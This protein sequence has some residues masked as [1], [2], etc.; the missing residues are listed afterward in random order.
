MALHSGL[1][2]QDNHSLNAAS[3]PDIATRNADLVFNDNVDNVNKLVRVNSPI[4]YFILSSINPPVW[5]EI[6]GVEAADTLAEILAIGNVT[7]GS[8]IVVDT[9]DVITLTD[10]PVAGTDGANKDYVDTQVSTSDEL[11][12]VLAIGNTTG[13]NDIIVDAGQVVTLNDG[14][15][16]GTDA[17]NKDYVDAQVG[18]NN[19]LS[20]ILV[21]GNT[22]G[23]T[24][25]L[26]SSGDELQVADTVTIGSLVSAPTDVS[27]FLSDSTNALLINQ[28]TTAQRDAIT[29]TEG[30]QYYNLDVNDLE[31]YNGVFWQSMGG[32]DV[33]GPAS[34]I[35]NQVVIFNGITGKNIQ[36]GVGVIIPAANKMTIGTPGVETPTL[37][38][39]STDPGTGGTQQLILAA[40]TANADAGLAFKTDSITSNLWQFYLSDADNALILGRVGGFEFFKVLSNGNV[41]I[42]TILPVS[43]LH[44]ETD[45]TAFGGSTGITMDNVAITGDAG[46]AFS[47]EDF[48]LNL[49]TIFLSQADG[50]LKFGR[51]D[52]PNKLVILDNGNIGIN[53]VLPIAVLDIVHP[54]APLSST[55]M[56]RVANDANWN[57]RILQDLDAGANI[58]YHIKQVAAS[59]EHDV[60]AFKSGDVGIGTVTPVSK[61]EVET[62]TA[63]L[64]GTKQLTLTNINAAGDAGIAFQTLNRT[65]SLWQAFLSDS[66]NRFTIG[67]DGIGNFLNILD[68]GNV[69]IG[70][71]APSNLLDVVSGV[72]GSAITIDG[73]FASKV[74]SEAT[75]IFTMADFPAPIGGLITLPSGMYII[76]E[77]LVTSD[78][79]FFDSG[80][81][82]TIRGDDLRNIIFTYTG[83]STMFIGTDFAAFCIENSTIVSVGDG[84]QFFDF[85]G[86]GNVNITSTSMAMFG[87]DGSLGN[88]DGSAQLIVR[89]VNGIGFTGGFVMNDI[90]IGQFQ[91]VGMQADNAID[92][93]L[94][95]ITGNGGPGFTFSFMFA[96]LPATGEIFDIEPSY[97]G[98]VNILAVVP[99]G[100]G[101]FFSPA[102]LSGSGPISNLSILNGLIA[103]V[104]D[105]GG[106]LASFTFGPSGLRVGDLVDHTGFGGQPS[107]NGVGLLITAIPDA[108]HY[109]IG[110]IAFVAADIGTLNFTSLQV[111]ISDLTHGLTD[112][113]AIRITDTIDYDG[114]YVV[115]DATP[116]EFR[117]T[118]AFSDPETAFWNDGSLDETVPSVDV[119]NCR[120]QKS[121]ANRAFGEM[122]AN[123]SATTILSVDTYVSL[124]LGTLIEDNSTERWTLVNS[125]NGTFRYDGISTFVGRIIA[126]IWATKSGSTRS[127]RF[128]VAI[129]GVPPV[130]ASAPYDPM[131]IQ[132]NKLQVTF[133]EP[134]TINPGQAVQI[135]IAEEGFTDNP[136]ITDFK[137]DIEGPI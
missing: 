117:I 33:V 107:Y 71:V 28:G 36:N 89:D 56:F 57:L 130:F 113:V 131:D 42:G 64:G 137:I 129:D 121:S 53:T 75:E 55:D 49:W 134:L 74:S 63:F 77:D 116:D 26:V 94:Y 114:G 1:K 128:A 35:D 52:T 76:K 18:A 43:K 100:A 47:V 24:D 30:M 82:V 119:L 90:S 79:F 83:T 66:D 10:A 34:S 8:N 60:L 87:L 5:E 95:Q 112:G 13:A 70:T 132:S 62:D 81:N 123:A 17:A 15:V 22:T 48:R 37:Y 91:N 20:E 124:D 97:Q 110:A 133:L 92:G 51:N 25:L 6:T 135:M 125:G 105:D 68:A 19:E 3:Y 50:A 73:K 54:Q 59:V 38:L 103:G 102:D 16:S 108:T 11:S 101:L 2:T 44:V 136:T 118:H 4:S 7:G 58:S 120:N 88:I 86:A 14:P 23:G 12:E 65:V 109:V 84:A 29:P 115:Q 46:M 9:G 72:S 27:L 127:Y 96:V 32:G 67:R 69:G 61:L 93:P 39:N 80:V 85:G 21:N 104:I 41:G 45:T 78:R 106:G 31:F 111:L 40:T 98:F 99:I 126:T 122:N